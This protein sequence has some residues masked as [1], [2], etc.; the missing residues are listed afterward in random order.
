MSEIPGDVMKAAIDAS[1]DGCQC[2]RCRP[3]AIA[4]AIMA[5]RDRC[6]AL[7]EANMLVEGSNGVEMIIP[8][9]NPGNKVGFA[10]AAAIR[11][12]TP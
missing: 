12:S 4:R 9:S 7:I 2:G 3:N 10:Y 11:R 8:R 5:E 6:A 1:E